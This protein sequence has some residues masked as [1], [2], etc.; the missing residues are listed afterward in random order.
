MSIK[1]FEKNN[2]FTIL[3]KNPFILSINNTNRNEIY[4]Y[5]KV[6]IAF[7]NISMAQIFLI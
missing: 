5:F 4:I 3:V 1:N 6:E 7:S 2:V